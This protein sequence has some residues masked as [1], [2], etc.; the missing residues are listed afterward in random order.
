MNYLYLFKKVLTTQTSEIEAQTKQANLRQ[1]VPKILSMLTS[2]PAQGANSQMKV[3]IEGLTLLNE[4]VKLYPD[5]LLQ[6]F[7]SGV[8]KTANQLKSHR[9]RVVRTVAR[10]TINEWSLLD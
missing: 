7:C 6:G 10:T 2:T 3:L 5:A 1:F 4:I 8:L 9:K